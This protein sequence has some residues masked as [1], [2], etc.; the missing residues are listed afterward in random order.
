M[1]FKGNSL[2]PSTQCPQTTVDRPWTSPL[3]WVERRGFD[4]S[5]ICVS[6][7]SGLNFGLSSVSSGQ[8]RTK[9]RSERETLSK[10]VVRPNRSD[11]VTDR[12]FTT[13]SHR[14][15]MK[16]IVLLVSEG[17]TLPTTFCRKQMVRTGN[18]TIPAGRG[19]LCVKESTY[20]LS[21][22]L[23]PSTGI[24]REDLSDECHHRGKGILLSV[25]VSGPSY[26]HKVDP[27]TGTPTDV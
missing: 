4:S 9:K 21:L 12:T 2:L 13:V 8:G 17:R 1:S 3:P 15:G 24:V 14:T 19:L 26:L 6:K 10:S 11:C 27:D 5:L 7:N 22:V 16:W 23:T 18:W 25:L 20:V